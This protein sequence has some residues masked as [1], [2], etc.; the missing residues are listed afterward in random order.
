MTE[1]KFTA[2]LGW[3][4]YKVYRHEI[5][6]AART[7]RLWV[8]RRRGNKVLIC[9]N[10]SGRARRVEKVRERELRHLPCMKHQ[11]WLL[12]EYYRVSC[13]KCEPR[14]ERVNQMPGKVPFAKDVEDEVALA[15]DIWNGCRRGAKIRC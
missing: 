7:L 10:C 13:L 15:C 4:G 12:V 14:T 3:P 11:T 2:I 8:R 5:D 1:R 6:E 9:S